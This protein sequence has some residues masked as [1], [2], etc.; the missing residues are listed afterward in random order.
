M[1]QSQS[2]FYRSVKSGLN[3]EQQETIIIRLYY[4]IKYVISEIRYFTNHKIV[5]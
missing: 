2:R 3:Y 1:H 4:K 5:L